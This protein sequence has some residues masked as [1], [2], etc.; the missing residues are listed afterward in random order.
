MIAEGTLCVHPVSSN[1]GKEASIT[2]PIYTSTAYSYLE[3]EERLYPGFLS[4]FNQIR[5]GEV[6]ARLER[7]N[8]GIAFNSGMAAISNTILSLVK[9][10]D[11]II[12]SRDLYGG[13]SQF[14]TDELIQRGISCDFAENTLHSFESKRQKNT[15]VVFFESPSN[16]LLNI[17]DLH[18]IALWAKKHELITIIDNTFATPINQKPLSFGIDIVVHSGTKY[19]S[20]HNDLVF[21]ATVTDNTFYKESILSTAKLYGGA[22]S[23]ALCYQAEKNIKTLALRVQQQ[24]RSAMQIALYLEKHPKIKKVYYPGLSSHPSYQLA[25]RQ[26]SAFGGMISFELHETAY[27]NP[28]LKNLNII[29]SALSLGGVESLIC[30]PAQTSHAAMTKTQRALLGISEELLRLSLGIENTDDL[31]HDIDSTLQCL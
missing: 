25:I 4:T 28:F 27:L 24:N 29:Q 11:H 26:M 15:R 22:L 13:T 18:E 20:G 17:I 8:Y 12:F 21:G 6:I 5:L 10:G 7:G 16:P 9:E 14:A 31:I 30:V 2:S 1:K 3:T 19:L 23:P